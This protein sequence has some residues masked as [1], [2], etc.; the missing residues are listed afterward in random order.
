MSRKS[1]PGRRFT[2][3]CPVKDGDKIESNSIASQRAICEDYIA[4]HDDL[5]I[6]CE[7]FVDDGY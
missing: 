4:Q 3:A 1:L 6:V 7:P 5:E 2:A